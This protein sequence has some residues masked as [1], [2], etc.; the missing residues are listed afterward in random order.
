MPKP[1][2]RPHRMRKSAYKNTT[3]NMGRVT[4]ALGGGPVFTWTM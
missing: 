3:V 4:T 2:D 1:S